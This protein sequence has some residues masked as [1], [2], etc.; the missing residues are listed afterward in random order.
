MSSSPSS[1]SIGSG[2]AGCF[3]SCLCPSR[4]GGILL[5]LGPLTFMSASS[6]IPS[7]GLRHPMGRL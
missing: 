7:L 2:L 6:C 4:T 5:G 1:I 3:R